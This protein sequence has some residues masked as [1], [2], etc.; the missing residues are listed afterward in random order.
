MS[1]QAGDPARKYAASKQY[2]ERSEGILDATR[3]DHGDPRVR[4]AV[5]E[6]VLYRLEGKIGVP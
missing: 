4:S 3:V 6:V 5:P 1:R 2:P